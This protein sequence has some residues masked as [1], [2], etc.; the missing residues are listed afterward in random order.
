MS[1]HQYTGPALAVPPSI[2]RVAADW[3]FTSNSPWNLPIASSALFADD[4]NIRGGS[5]NINSTTLENSSS[6]EYC[7]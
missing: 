6:R 1:I 7:R 2:T 5:S 3:P 4:A